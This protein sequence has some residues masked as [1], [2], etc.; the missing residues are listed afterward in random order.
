MKV[1]VAR[2][3]LQ[4]FFFAR[5]FTRFA[6][7]A[8]SKA[9]PEHFDVLLGGLAALQDELRWFQV[10]GAAPT[11]HM[12]AFPQGVVCAAWWRPRGSQLPGMTAGWLSACS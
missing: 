9:P 2:P 8:L 4:D 3:R 10:G 7:L 1:P 11:T 6:A 12:F 5:E